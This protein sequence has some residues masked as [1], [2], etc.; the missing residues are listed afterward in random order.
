MP[1]F[2]ANIRVEGLEGENPKQVRDALQAKLMKAEVGDCRV[3]SIDQVK[4]RPPAPAPPRQSRR[5]APA[6]GT[7]RRQS[8]AAGLLLLLA[9]GWA[10]WFFWSFFSLYVAAD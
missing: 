8:N 7:W 2:R 1:V 4:Q 3:L 5:V 10:V 9:V 6:E